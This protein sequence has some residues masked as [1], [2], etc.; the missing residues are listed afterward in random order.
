MSDKY[1]VISVKIDS[2]IQEQFSIHPLSH[3]INEA[4][5]ESV[6]SQYFAMSQAF[7]YIQAGA[8]KTQILSAMDNNEDMDQCLE[9]TSVVGNF[10]CWDET[11]GIRFN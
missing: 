9:Y 11:G 5:A 7:P 2:I 10:L 3:G 6:L 8:Q 4:N 1:K